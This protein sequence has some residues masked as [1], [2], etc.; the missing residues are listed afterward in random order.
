MGL[1]YQTAC[2]GGRGSTP[3]PRK[4]ADITPTR[5]PSM[6]IRGSRMGAGKHPTRLDR[7]LD[8]QAGKWSTGG[9]GGGG[10]DGEAMVVSP[11]PGNKIKKA[12]S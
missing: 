10:G 3:D 4:H 5:T 8:G 9:S 1:I 2:E 12:F 7:C 6:V 11:S